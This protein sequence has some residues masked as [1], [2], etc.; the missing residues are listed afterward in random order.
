MER[1]K[2][3]NLQSDYFYKLYGKEIVKR[4]RREAIQKFGEVFF[5]AVNLYGTPIRPKT[6]RVQNMPSFWEFVRF[7]LNTKRYCRD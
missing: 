1:L 3:P 4:H 5:N 6:K 7:I 2:G